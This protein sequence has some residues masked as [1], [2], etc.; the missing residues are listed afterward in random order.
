MSDGIFDHPVALLV[1][2]RWRE[3]MRE[4]GVLFWTFG[5][6]I[7]L[8]IV[9]SL[10]F[11][12]SGPEK[13]TIAIVDI[14]GAEGI[15]TRIDASDALTSKRLSESEARKALKEGRA[16]LV[17]VPGAAPSFILDET[18]PDSAI[19]SAAV[20]EA[21]AGR[22]GEAIAVEKVSAQGQRYVDFLLPG[23]IGMTL[24]N[25]G[26]WGVGYGLILMRTRKLL[27]RL[28]ATP[29]KRSHLLGAYL[30]FRIFMSLSE[31]FVL[32]VIGVLA[33]HMQIAGSV[34]GLLL[35]VTLSAL[36]FGGLGLLCAAKA[37]NPQTGNGYVNLATIP[38]LLLSGV[39]F[40]AKNFPDWMRA[41]IDLLPL[42]AFNDALRAIVNDGATLSA[43]APQCAVL[44]VW[45]VAC[46]AFALRIFKWS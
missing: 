20:R 4:P 38:M 14:E 23:M 42:T 13:K 29:M 16:G 31:T 11:R 40:S 22:K 8:V 41:F 9:L 17:V 18:K 10:A 6:P 32:L 33:F 26:A 21:L 15:A 39:F 25:G 27:K 28:C 30:I 24:L 1:R 5:F 7:L 45:G 2:E 19:V 37:E 3:F 34:L 43:V 35:L 44:A 46:F 36:S 12:G